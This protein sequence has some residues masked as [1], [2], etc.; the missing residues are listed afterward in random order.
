MLDKDIPLNN[1]N[2]PPSES[3]TN[4]R[5][6][7][8]NLLHL[9]TPI[10]LGYVYYKG[11][12][13]KEELQK[14]LETE[15]NFHKNVKSDFIKYDVPGINKEEFW[16]KVEKIKIEEEHRAKIEL[17]ELSKVENGIKHILDIHCSWIKP[18]A[19]REKIEK[20]LLELSQ[21]DKLKYL[22]MQDGLNNIF[23]YDTAHCGG[24][25]HNNGQI[26]RVWMQLWRSRIEYDKQSRILARKNQLY[27]EYTL[28]K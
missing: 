5:W 1:L 22:K 24:G 12:T 2:I 28:I 9:L 26:Y 7:W 17:Q 18:R 25:F 21:E 14:K 23:Q 11:K 20:S 6:D 8:I 19:D 10:A 3:G 27:K 13:E 4:S 16:H 15:I